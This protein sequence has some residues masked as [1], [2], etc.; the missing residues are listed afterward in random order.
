MIEYAH[1]F[2][3]GDLDYMLYN[4]NEYGGSGV[5]LAIRTREIGK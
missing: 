4:G 5:G 3:H 1:I 2:S